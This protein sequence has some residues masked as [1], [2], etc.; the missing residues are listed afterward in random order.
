MTADQHHILLLAGTLEA[1]QLVKQ[2]TGAFPDFQLTASFAGVVRDLPDLG[3]PTRI[4]GFGGV[5]GLVDYAC[6]ESVSL[7]IDATHPF[8]AQMSWNALKVAEKLGLPLI[9]LERPKWQPGRGDQWNHVCSMADAVSE[10]P[11]GARAFLAVGRKEIGAFYKR[12]DIYGLV[13]M[14]EPPE[15]VLPS[16]W[17]LILSRPPQDLNEEIDLFRNNRITHLVTKN[18]GGTRSFAKIEAAR[19]MSLPVIMIDRPDL[20]E[21][22]TAPNAAQMREH[23]SAVLSIGKART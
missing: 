3:V 11:S 6:A 13:R 23:I 21:T 16:K 5:D 20:P 7:I 14:I 4:G 22:D 10:I 8:A 12:S 18:S 9:R 2:I 17:D 19:Q 15:Q 1:R